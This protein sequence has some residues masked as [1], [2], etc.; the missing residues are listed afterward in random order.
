MPSDEPPAAP[1]AAPSA[2]QAV[3]ERFEM[4]AQQTYFDLMDW[5]AALQLWRTRAALGPPNIETQLALAH[6]R[7]EMASEAE[8]ADITIANPTA[9]SNG[10][11][12]LH[13]HLMRCRAYELLQVGDAA[14]AAQIM[15]L[16]AAAE[17]H[18]R[19]LY[20]EAIFA[21]ANAA[22]AGIPP[23]ADPGIALP[24]QRAVNLDDQAARAVIARHAHRRVLLAVRNADAPSTAAVP[25]IMSTSLGALGIRWTGLN[26][27]PDSVEP[28]DV[29]IDRLRATLADFRPDVIVYDEMFVA[30]PAGEK[31]VWERILEVLDAARRTHG[32]KLMYT[33]ADAWYDGMAELYNT[34]FNL[35]DL[36]HMSH[37][38]LL[39]QL[40]PAAAER[41]FCYP[42]PAIDARDPHAAPQAQRQRGSFVGS[43]S[44]V[45]PSRLAWCAEIANVG[46]PV[47]IHLS[48][49]QGRSPAEYGQ[50]IGEYAI[51]INFTARSNDTKILTHRTVEVPCLGSLLL[52]EACADTPYFMRPFD[53]YVPF[54]TL[55]ELQARLRQLIEEPDLRE[56]IAR[57]GTRWARRYFTGLHFWAGA[58]HRLYEVEVRPAAPPKSGKAVH[59]EIPG[60]PDSVIRY[61]S[62]I[63]GTGA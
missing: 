51:G 52:E 42:A 29:Y 32:T 53:H 3:I 16:V 11:R 25:H 22:S 33:H 6:C 63:A 14:R 48:T 58:L 61:I 39:R 54:A 38:G 34:A 15:R 31:G 8:L 30:G 17:P 35:G 21:P 46:L 55:A 9:A 28:R 49:T 2:P 5:G 40:S 20:D 59:I 45:T 13:L 12:D 60:P 62:R 47:D 26:V 24:F 18:L 36:F 23:P 7:A 50:L 41:V 56:R 57:S 1:P 44:W 10:N 37:P 19:R 27:A 4:V 43:L